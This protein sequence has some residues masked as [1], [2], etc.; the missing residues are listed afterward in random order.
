MLK[1][2]LV[3]ILYF[4][5]ILGFAWVSGQLFF[6]EKT[7]Q[8][9]ADVKGV[10]VEETV[11]AGPK[12]KE[13]R[14]VYPDEAISLEPTLADPV[15]RQRLINIYEPIVRAD[16]DLKMR[17]ALAISWGLLD[18]YT[19]EFRLRPDVVFHNGSLFTADDVMASI[20]R[21]REYAGSEFKDVL[22]SIEEVTKVDD[23]TL[24]VKTFAPDP[25]LLQ[26]LST[27]LIIPAEN[28]QKENFSP[29][30]TAS[31]SFVSWKQG[32]NVKLKRFEDYWGKTAKFETVT[33]I[34]KVNKVERVQM[35]IDGEADLLAFV[36]FDAAEFVKQQKF[37]IAAI[38]SL[39]VQFLLFNFDSKLLAEVDARRAVSLAMDTSS[40]TSLLGSYA[41]PVN[42]FVSNG[43]FGF[44]Q[45]I[46]EHEYD[47]EKAQILAEESQLV[48]KTLKLH[49]AKGLDVLGEHVR[50]Q[51]DEIGIN[52]IVSYL[53]LD[54]LWDSIANSDAD[55]YF[56]GFKAD[57]GDTGDFLDIVIHTN[58]SFNVA[59]Y[60]DKVVD[61]LI[62][63]SKIEMDPTKR[64]SALQE[65]M[66]LIVTEDVIGVPLFEY[67]TLY[68]FSD[69][70]DLQPRIDGFLY[71]DELI[72]K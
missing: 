45:N 46:E 12:I 4:V 61:E 51:L 41:R 34:P 67:E 10:F 63:S 64:L 54:K 69:G 32:E 38:P 36:P 43:I 28:E 20:E 5:F 30:G 70:L 25:L 57:F 52:V 65:I 23:L 6:E 31:Y 47:L 62:D 1:K 3:N 2:L 35:L 42:Q 68:A 56:L 16:R 9:L 50:T 40:L 71:F 72:P 29:I 8:L 33:L 49:L 60:S 26:R 15:T 58:G 27:V 18:S 14:V 24:R 59:N 13:L 55:L 44:N 21:A 11:Y 22:A 17:P 7:N 19:W 39:E 37:Q 66:R 53:E 48:G